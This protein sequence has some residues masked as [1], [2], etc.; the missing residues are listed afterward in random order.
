MPDGEVERLPAGALPAG[1]TGA[2][3][4]GFP[5]EL[6]RDCLPADGDRLPPEGDR[7]PPEGEG[8]PDGDLELPLE[9]PLPLEELFLEGEIL[10]LEEGE[11][12]PLEELFREGLFLPL[13][14]REGL[15]LP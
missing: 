2:R 7:L 13:L 14:F 6:K 10:P 5:K 1:A 11:I 9:L 3:L 4:P 12:L 8:L 15:F